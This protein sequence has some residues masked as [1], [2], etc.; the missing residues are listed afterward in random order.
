MEKMQ[1]LDLLVCQM[2]SHLTLTMNHHQILLEMSRRRNHLV[3]GHRIGS[4]VGL[5]NH[6]PN[7]LRSRRFVIAVVVA[8]VVGSFLMVV[9]YMMC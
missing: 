6:L 9:E 1:Y 2:G 8:V 4:M 3:M 7:Y 5:A